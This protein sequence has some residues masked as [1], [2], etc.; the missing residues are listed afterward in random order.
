LLPLDE[1]DE[2]KLLDVEAFK[3]RLAFASS[4]ELEK[5]TSLSSQATYDFLILP[6]L[7]PLNY[8]FSLFSLLGQFALMCPC[9]P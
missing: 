6:L 9:S 1:E 8:V 3:H 4:E 2:L 5:D 7:S